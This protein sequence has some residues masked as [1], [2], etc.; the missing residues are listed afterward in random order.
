MTVHEAL[1]AFIVDELLDGDGAGL[2]DG[3]PLLETGVLDSLSVVSLLAFLK[4]RF[5]LEVPQAEV[6][7]KNLRNLGAIVAL[8]ERL[9]AGAETGEL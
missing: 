8:V 1:R 5:G 6:T 3:T 7:P 4:S 2:E 9:S